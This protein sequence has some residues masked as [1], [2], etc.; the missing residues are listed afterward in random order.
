MAQARTLPST[1]R[2]RKLHEVDRGAG[3]PRHGR[4]E[5]FA[6]L[7]IARRLQAGTIHVGQLRNLGQANATAQYNKNGTAYAGAFTVA[8]GVWLY[9][10]QGDGLAMELTAKGTKY[11]RYDE[12]N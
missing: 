7:G 1:S 10:L 4:E 5:V 11:S 3:R 8:N 9:Q 6:D 12:L 2:A